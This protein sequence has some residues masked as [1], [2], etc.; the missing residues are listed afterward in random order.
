M[1]TVND[2]PFDAAKVSEM[3]TLIAEG[4]KETAR[5][6]EIARRADDEAR[7]AEVRLSNL[8]SDFTRL[9]NDRLDH[10]VVKDSRLRI[11]A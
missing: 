3:A 8:K 9:V 11:P 4:E 1:S 2:K 5:L 7:S 6:R 10:G